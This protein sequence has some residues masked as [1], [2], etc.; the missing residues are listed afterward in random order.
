MNAAAAFVSPSA[1]AAAA[2]CSRPPP[3]AAAAAVS[4]ELLSA[5]VA[6]VQ[7]QSSSSAPAAAVLIAPPE[8]RGAVAGGSGRCHCRVTIEHL[9][10][11]KLG[12]CPDPECKHGIGYHPTSVAAHHSSVASVAVDHTASSTNVASSLPVSVVVRRRSS[13]AVSL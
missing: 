7:R 2:V 12:S 4:A 6:A 10:S 11:A 9:I 13:S 1:P 8:C 5:A 3:A